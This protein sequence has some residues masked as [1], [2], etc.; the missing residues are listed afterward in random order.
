MRP[1]GTPKELEAR[2]MLAGRLVKEGFATGEVARI[3]GATPTTVCRWKKAMRTGGTQALKAKRHPGPR[4]RLTGRQ[5]LRLKRILV[6]G[7][8]KAGFATDLWTCGRVAQVIQQRFGVEYHPDH[9]WRIL[10]GM[11]LSCQK[12]ER[13]ARERDDLAIKRWRGRDWPRIKKSRG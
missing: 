4:P 8:L 6:A 2:R 10:T 11:G 9:V 13:R 7:P 3:V 1:K 5:K 12:P